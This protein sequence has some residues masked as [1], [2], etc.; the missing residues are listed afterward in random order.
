MKKLIVAVAL[1]AAVLGGSAAPL[2]AADSALI[3]VPGGK[4]AR[5]TQHWDWRDRCAWLNYYCLYAWHGYVYHYP[6]DDLRYAY[7][8]RRHRR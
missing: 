6:Y 8:P 7:V 3:I 1:G 2:R 4:H 5:I